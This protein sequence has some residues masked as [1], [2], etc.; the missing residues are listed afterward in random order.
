MCIRDRQMRESTAPEVGFHSFRQSLVIAL[1]ECRYERC[2]PGSCPRHRFDDCGP[3]PGR[4]R[5]PPCGGIG[6]RETGRGQCGRGVGPLG[7]CEAADGRQ[8]LA[9]LEVAG[10]PASKHRDRCPH[11]KLLAAC[12]DA[13]NRR[14]ENGQSRRQPA[15][16]L[17][18]DQ[19]HGDNGVIVREVMKR[20]RIQ[21][22]ST[23]AR[24]EG[25]GGSHHEHQNGKP[26]DATRPIEHEDGGGDTRDE[27]DCRRGAKPMLK[28]ECG[29]QPCRQGRDRHPYVVHQ[30]VTSGLSS[31]IV[32]GPIPFTSINSSMREKRPC[33]PRQAM[34]AP[35]VTGPTPGSVSSCAS[36][37]EL[38]LTFAP[39]APG[40]PSAEVPAGATGSMPTRI[41]SPSLST[42]AILSAVVSALPSS[43]PAALIAPI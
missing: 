14:F 24:E 28:D 26:G 13:P 35:T 10:V 34:I 23:G 36:V 5:P 42:R 25:Y 7:G 31:A 21:G 19:V 11:P 6:A 18:D 27:S 2:G 32:A 16:I 29:G 17:T 30:I 12:V 43:P 41:C 1:Y 37:A 33:S 22:G 38:R 9:H 40:A 20:T 15:G 8:P 39:A 3:H 4:C